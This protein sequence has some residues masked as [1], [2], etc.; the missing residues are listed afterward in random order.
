MG[1]VIAE[2]KQKRLKIISTRNELAGMKGVKEKRSRHF[3]KTLTR[4]S[5]CKLQHSSR[6][7]LP[8]SPT[9]FP[10]KFSTRKSRTAIFWHRLPLLYRPHDDEGR[11]KVLRMK[12]LDRRGEKSRKLFFYI[13]YALDFHKTATWAICFMLRMYFYLLF[14]SLFCSRAKSQQKRMKSFQDFILLLFALLIA[15]HRKIFSRSSCLLYHLK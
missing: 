2:R 1:V 4:L 7:T 9:D 14:T 11:K 12:S 8:R 13:I 10:R 15:F 6:K 3:L 5:R